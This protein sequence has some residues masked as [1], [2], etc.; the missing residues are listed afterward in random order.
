MLY[1]WHLLACLTYYVYFQVLIENVKVYW[2]R[3]CYLL[4]DKW[5]WCPRLPLVGS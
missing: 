3:L 4:G 5:S 1:A 2:W